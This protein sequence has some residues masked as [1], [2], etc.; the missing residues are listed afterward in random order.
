VILD[1]RTFLRSYQVRDLF[2]LGA[3]LNESPHIIECVCPDDVARRRLE[4][5][6]ARGQHPA[7]NRTYDLYLAVKAA[8][9]PLQT[10]HLVL[11]T[12]RPLGECLERCLRYLNGAER[13]PARV[14]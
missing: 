12:D 13:L 3:S 6:L 10:A 9:E 2:A 11:D 5:D 8:A 1:G 4:D 7:R 14:S